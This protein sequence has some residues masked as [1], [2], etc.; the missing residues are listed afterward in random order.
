MKSLRMFALVV[1]AAVWPA[2]LA[3][4]QAPTITTIGVKNTQCF[5]KAGSKPC[6]IGPGM[7]ININGS[8]FGKTAGGV[9][10][11]DCPAATVIS[12]AQ[13]RV[14][15]VVNSVTPNASLY[16]ET[17]GGALSNA[18]PYNPLG[19]VITSIVVGNCTYVPNQ[20]PNLCKVAPGTQFTI[21]GSYFGPVTDNGYVITCGDCGVGTATINSW[22]PDWLTNPSPY[23]NQIEATANQAICGS[24]IGVFVDGIWSN[25]VPYTAC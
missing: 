20:S 12:W 18:I 9:I 25:Y 16:L 13:N 4:A 15:V 7:T 14:T 22:N 2:A 3:F 8:N 1:L 24:T 21:N 5:Y 11:C 19:P 10:L 17:I 23:N 6:N